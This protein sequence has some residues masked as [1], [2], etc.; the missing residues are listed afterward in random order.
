MLQGFLREFGETGVS[1]FVATT[2]GWDAP[3]LND[4]TRP[5]YPR[6]QPLSQDETALVDAT[7]T[8]IGARIQRA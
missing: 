7:L 8:E 6:A 1:R 5:R 2:D 3:I 4:R